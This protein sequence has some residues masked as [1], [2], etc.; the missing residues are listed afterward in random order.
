MIVTGADVKEIL[1]RP[2]KRARL[3]VVAFAELMVV[4]MAA[5]LAS[6]TEMARSCTFSA[7]LPGELSTRG[8]RSTM[9][10]ATSPVE[11]TRVREIRS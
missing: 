1:L 6:I 10:V 9:V 2:A 4:S 3:P 11:S 8:V 5:I 7:G